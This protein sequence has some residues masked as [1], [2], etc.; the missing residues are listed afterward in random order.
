M[1]ESSSSQAAS[2]VAWDPERALKSMDANEVR[3]SRGFLRSRPE[4]WFPS[5]AAQWLPLAHSLGVEMKLV[6]VRPVLK[7]PASYSRVYAA[8]IDG[9]PLAM[10]C[11]EGTFQNI[12]EGVVPSSIPAGT[13]IV[14]EYLA[15]RLL[16]S[17]ALSW[18]GPESTVV[19]FDLALDISK[20][21]FL[22][23]VKITFSLNSK[24]CNVWMLTGRVLVDRLDNLW[25]K[26]I[27][28]SAK[29]GDQTQELHLELVQLAVPPSTL[30]EYL[31]PGAKIDLELALTDQ[32]V[33]RHQGR[34]V[35]SGRLGTLGA[36]FGLEILAQP[37]LTP[38][39]PEGMTRLAVEFGQLSLDPQVLAECAQGGAMLDTRIA[40]SNRVNMCVNQEVVGSASLC[41]FE[42]RFAIRVEG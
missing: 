14:A 9:E 24:V 26:Q 6:E 20:I 15:R 22:A 21:N 16:G 27:R 41:S 11:D 36:N 8:S 13:E 4:R 35:Y 28:S 10:V 31:H 39:L 42:G 32:I 3:L 18:S 5:F 19:H 1:Q 7:G 40:L 23:A 38:S 12:L 29:M 33:L 37:P 25:R 34:S 17:L 30:V 2:L